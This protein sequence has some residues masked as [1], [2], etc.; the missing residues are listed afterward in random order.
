MRRPDPPGQM[1]HPPRLEYPKA[2]HPVS[3]V[4]H[5]R[6]ARAVAMLRG[7]TDPDKRIVLSFC[8]SPLL[9]CAS[10]VLVHAIGCC[11]GGFLCLASG[12]PQALQ[13][14]ARRLSSYATTADATRKRASR[15]NRLLE[16]VLLSLNAGA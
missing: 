16:T 11:A 6:P 13:L 3:V 15:V 12:R 4:E 8:G 2:I 14:M 9:S 5:S 1:N 7:P 10:P